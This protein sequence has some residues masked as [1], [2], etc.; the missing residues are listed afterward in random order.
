MRWFWRGLLTL[1]VLFSLLAGTIFVYDR[2]ERARIADFY[3]KH[4][5]LNAMNKTP[6]VRLQGRDMNP[7]MSEVLL[8]HVPVGTIRSEASQILVAEGFR[9]E[10]P[11]ALLQKNLLICFLPTRPSGVPQWQAELTF[12]AGDRVVAGRAWAV[13]TSLP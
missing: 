12:D 13:D 5:I 9:C 1:I 8:R 6:R 10:M 7:Q 4:P 3:D 11:V 2:I